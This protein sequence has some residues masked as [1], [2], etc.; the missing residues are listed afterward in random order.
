MEEDFE[1]DGGQSIEIE[2]SLNHGNSG[3]PFLARLTDGHVR[4]CPVVSSGGDPNNA[5]AGDDDTLIRIH[6]G[7]SNWTA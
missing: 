7:R 4:L 6:W 3:G 5:L 1:D 2:A